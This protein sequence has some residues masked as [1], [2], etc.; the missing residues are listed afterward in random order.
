MV[1]LRLASELGAPGLSAG[2][3]KAAVERVG[4]VVEETE[5]PALQAS[6]ACSCSPAAGPQP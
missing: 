1:L 4:T 6:A 2:D 3:L 5:V